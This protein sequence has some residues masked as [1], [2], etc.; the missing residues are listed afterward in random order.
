MRQGQ[1]ELLTNSPG[2]GRDFLSEIGLMQAAMKEVDKMVKVMLNFI[3]S[4]ETF[5]FSDLTH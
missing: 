1:W 3:V 2:Q 5:A 4:T